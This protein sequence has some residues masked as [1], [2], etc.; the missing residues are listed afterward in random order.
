[1]RQAVLEGRSVPRAA[2]SE[3]PSLATARGTD[4]FVFSMES[5]GA[6][7]SIFIYNQSEAKGDQ[8]DHA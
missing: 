5:T 3:S 2:A 8:K 7:Q 4:R 1:M 6:L